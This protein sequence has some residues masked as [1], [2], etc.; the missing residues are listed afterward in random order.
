MQ[1]S[2][3]S[4]SWAQITRVYSWRKLRKRSPGYIESFNCNFHLIL[5]DLCGSH[6][7]GLKLQQG[8]VDIWF[9]TLD[10]S[11]F[12]GSCWCGLRLGYMLILSL[13]HG[14]FPLLIGV[15]WGPLHTWANSRDLVMVRTLDSHPLKRIIGWVFVC[16][17]IYLEIYPWNMF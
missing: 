17:G 1:A 7:K 4:E 6:S 13:S 3:C 12:A 10:F 16:P 11:E 15:I 2:T 9:C 5:T 14:T 8:H